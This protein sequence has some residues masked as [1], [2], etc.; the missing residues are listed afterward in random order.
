[1]LNS[2]VSSEDSIYMSNDLATMK[3]SS[4]ERNGRQFLGISPSQNTTI[5]NYLSDQI[6]KQLKKELNTWNTKGI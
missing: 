4:L 3:A 1:M 6:E 5:D 2:L